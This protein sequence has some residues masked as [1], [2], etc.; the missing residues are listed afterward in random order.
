M[1]VHELA[2]FGLAGSGI[3]TVL[4]VP[5]A[6]PRGRRSPDVQLLGLTTILLSLIAGLISARVA[7]LVSPAGPSEHIVNLIGLATLPLLVIYIRQATGAAPLC[8]GVGFLWVPAVVYVGY[9]IAGALRGFDTDVPFVWLLPVVLGFTC[10]SGAYLWRRPRAHASVLV[11]PGWV[12]GFL[13]VV[14]AAQ[15]IRML[16]GHVELVRAIVPLV[17]SGGFVALV[18]F[19]AWRSGAGRPEAAAPRYQKSGL[20]ETIA[21]DLLARI[22]R[23]LMHDRL[24]ARHDLTLGDLARAAG[25]TPHQV[26]EAL[27]H[28]AGLSFHDLLSRRRVEDVKAQL[29][30]PASDRYTIEGIG[31]TAGFGS[32]SALYAAFRKI[33]GMTPTAF[34]AA[35]RG[36]PGE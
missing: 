16:F 12:V 17:M 11:P 28:Y 32:R 29:L 27:N 36:K 13:A 34:R 9:C 26:S 5:L 23:A 20:D 24:F 1:G 35:A 30:E 10:G 14:N 25:S 33:E 6:W 3:G 7:G 15:V 22:D 8:R 31:H 21:P 19:V 18:A 4:G 2:V